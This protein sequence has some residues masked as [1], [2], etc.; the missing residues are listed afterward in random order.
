LAGAHAFG[1]QTLAPLFEPRAVAVI[2]A[3]DDPSRIGGRPV[4][5]CRALGYAGGLFPVNPSRS[6]IQGLPCHPDLASIGQPVD[7]A[8]IA[9]PAAHCEA[10]LVQC[11]QA[12]V[13]AAVVLSAGFAEVD[14][15]GAAL[16]ERLRGI[17]RQAGIRLLGPNCMGLLNLRLGLAASFTSLVDGGP[18]RVGAISV[19]SQSGAFGSHCLA[20]MRERGLGL[21]LWA[22]TGNQSDVDFAEGLAWMAQAPHTRVIVGCL[23]GVSDGARLRDAFALA[24]EHRKP[25]VLMKLG[26]SEVGRTAALTHTAALTGSDAVFDALLRDYAVHRANDVDELFDI[27]YACTAGRFPASRD[28]GLIT[29]S[30]GF[31]IVMADAAAAHGL[32]VPALPAATQSRLK[33]L[34]PFASPLNPLDVT[35]QFIN[36]PSAVLPMFEA[37]IQEG[38]CP[39]TVCYIGSA[40]VLPHLMDKLAPSFESV[41]RRFSDQL[42]MLSMITDAATRRRFEALGYLVFENPERAVGAVAALARLARRFGRRPPDV[43]A[44]PPAQASPAP[45]AAT[46]DEAHSKRIL[47]QAGVPMLDERIARSADEAALLAAEVG[48]PVAMKILSPDI[49]HKSDIGG[50]L[51]GVPDAAAAARGFAQLQKAA[52]AAAPQA[53]LDGVLIAPMVDDGVELIAGCHQDPVFGPVVMLGLGGIFV[54]ALG[55]TVLRMAP[56]DTQAAHAMIGELRGAAMLR[57]ARGRPAADTAALADALVALSRFAA[58]NAAWLASVDINPL[59]VRAEGRGAVALDAVVATRG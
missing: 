3:S 22:T 59:V 4:A 7:L 1:L 51:L 44:L 47:A 20:L 27:A 50:V 43:A 57:G 54:E 39:S 56:L 13:R 45:G 35:G 16:Q 21:D 28:V 24:R 17:A 19:I 26:R 36:D 40:G 8:V 9:L 42:L 55:A 49:L 52:R 30:G 14:A 32:A 48:F 11:A 23:E 25:V 53:R 31:G 15:D 12:G 37:L 34:V 2:G 38:G 41:A 46:L 6:R 29:T 10:A 5:A 33:A 18:E 58:A